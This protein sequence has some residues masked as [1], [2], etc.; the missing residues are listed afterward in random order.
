MART[1]KSRRIEARVDSESE[2]RIVEAAAMSSESI[3][4]FIVRAARTEA[5]RVLGR[6]DLTFMPA[7]QFDTIVASLDQPEEAPA[8]TRAATAE[9]SFTRA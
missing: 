8:L 1:A 3:S 7:E 5:D 6:A 4:A 9:R 2:R